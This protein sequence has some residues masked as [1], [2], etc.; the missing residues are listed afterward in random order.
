MD[1]IFDRSKKD[2]FWNGKGTPTTIEKEAEAVRLYLEMLPQ[3]AKR[4]RNPDFAKDPTQPEFFDIPEKKGIDLE[5]ASWQEI[6][7]YL[8]DSTIKKSES[9]RSLCRRIMAIKFPIEFDDAITKINSDLAN[10]YNLLKQQKREEISWLGEAGYSKTVRAD[11][12]FLKRR[13]NAST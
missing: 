7:D 8:N 10:E 12:K 11:K 1:I 4:V 6:Q 2:I 9:N 5:T 3:P 13:G